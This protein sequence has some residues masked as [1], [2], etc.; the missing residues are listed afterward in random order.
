MKINRWLAT[1]FVVIALSSVTPT[2][3]YAGDQTI[4]CN[5]TACSGINGALFSESNLVPG[6]LIT[7][8]FT[9]DN[10]DNPD[11]CNLNLK[12][13][14][15]SLSG[16]GDHSLFAEKLQTVIKD[17]ETEYFDQTMARLFEGG[18]IALGTIPAY[19]KSEYI[20]TVYLNSNMGNNYQDA[21]AQFDF[22]ISFACGSP[23]I[24]GESVVGGVESERVLGES[25]TDEKIW[26]W[27][28]L[29]A[30][31]LL[32]IFF[33][34]RRV[35]RPILLVLGLSASSQMAHLWLGCNCTTLVWCERYWIFNLVILAMMLVME[36]RIAMTR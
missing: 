11:S 17:G 14:N 20:W 10:S 26:W 16:K 18:S 32:G 5:A 35:W 23:T 28:P 8:R 31:I 24:L 6:D 22:E 36:R 9:L 13:K 21:K 30:Q 27:M 25:C 12:T 2:V 4:V 34:W 3:V 7:R 15:N 19:G 1:S 33:I 29:L